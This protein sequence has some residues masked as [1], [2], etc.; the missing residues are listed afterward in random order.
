MARSLKSMGLVELDSL[1]RRARRQ[2][3][4]KRISPADCEYIVN[5]LDTLEA[6]IVS[7]SEKSDPEFV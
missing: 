4:L 2:L 5:L 7:M 3:A 1:R 6:R